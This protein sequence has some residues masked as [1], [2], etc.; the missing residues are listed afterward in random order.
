MNGTQNGYGLLDVW[1]THVK[2]RYNAGELL[3]DGDKSL[4][5]SDKAEILL[6]GL[7]CEVCEN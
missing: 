4:D 6:T 3:H 7:P 2:L 5:V 1:L